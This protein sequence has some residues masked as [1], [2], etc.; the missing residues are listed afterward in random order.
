MKKRFLIMIALVCCLVL[1]AGI[2]AAC[3]S[4]EGTQTGGQTPG[5]GTPGIGDND[6]VYRMVTF[7]LNGGDGSLAPRKYVVGELMVLPTP[8]RDGFRFIGWQ[9]AS[10]REYD[11]STAMPDKNLTLYAQWEAKV[12]IISV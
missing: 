3:N 6:E 11:D 2:L 4:N 1:A 12:G 9:D 7:D 5:G 10:G 8:T